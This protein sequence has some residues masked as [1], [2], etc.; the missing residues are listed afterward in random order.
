[1]PRIAPE[2][3]VNGSACRFPAR[4]DR[5]S[6]V[7]QMPE[8][9]HGVTDRPL[10]DNMFCFRAVL[11]EHGKLASMFKLNAPSFVEASFQHRHELNSLRVGVAESTH[12]V[13]P[14][15]DAYASG[16]SAE[17]CS[18]DGVKVSAQDVL[19]RHAANEARDTASSETARAPVTDRNCSLHRAMCLK[20][21]LEVVV[22]RI[23]ARLAAG[24]PCGHSAS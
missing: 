21:V 22:S 9:R 12:V 16:V 19:H 7:E 23:S 17:A 4:S 13:D 18:A 11:G 20:G 14:S 5:C 2:S 10:L 3:S 15:H 8:N 1:M 24:T 6:M